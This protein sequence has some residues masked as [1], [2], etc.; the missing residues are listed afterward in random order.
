MVDTA[1]GIALDVEAAPAR[2]ANEPK[3]ARIIVERMRARHR[4][5]PA[6]M[7][8][9]SAYG[10]AA[11]FGWAK[12]QGILLHAP[13]RETRPAGK[14]RHPPKEDFRYEEASDTYLCPAG[15]TLRPQGSKRGSSEG[16]RDDGMRVYYPSRHG[17]RPCP[18]R[19]TCAPT[20]IRMIH[21]SPREEARE[22]AKTREGTT[23]FKRSKKL[24]MLV[25]RLFADIKHNDGF[26][27]VR[28]RGR[29]GADEQFVLAATARNLK[30]MITLLDNASRPE[31]RAASRP[32]S[33]CRKD[34]APSERVNLPTSSTATSHRETRPDPTLA[35]QIT[36]VS[37]PY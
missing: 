4:I 25:E 33:P 16:R 1:S 21:R 2:I 5:V 29:R 17:C 31:G 9:D 6:V 23:D 34:E 36:L 24:R 32:G 27:R 11:F 8:A 20:G 14:Q 22:R 37:R 26:R 28:L 7:A 18:L 3:A 19:E 30:R 12:D 13:V 35:K 15:K 10:S